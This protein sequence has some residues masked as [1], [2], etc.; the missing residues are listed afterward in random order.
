M[1]KVV[2]KHYPASRLPDELRA[3]IDPDAL[4]HVTIEEEAHPRPSLEELRARLRELPKT[5]MNREEIVKRIRDLRDE[6][7]D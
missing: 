5:P 2:R 6:W 7:D 1:N 4:V 3:G